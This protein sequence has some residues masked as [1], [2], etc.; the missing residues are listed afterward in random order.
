MRLRDSW[1]RWS[2]SRALIDDG[3][4][5]REIEGD[6]TCVG[7]DAIGS[8]IAERKDKGIFGEQ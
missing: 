7:R 5:N 3:D 8:S 4:M 6:L 1:K 2:F